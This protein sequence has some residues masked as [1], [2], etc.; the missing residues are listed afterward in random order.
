M[1]IA[2]DMRRSAAAMSGRRSSSCAGKATG[3]DG[4]SGDCILS[5]V[6]GR[7]KAAGGFPMRPDQRIRFAYGARSLC[8]SAGVASQPGHG[9]NSRSFH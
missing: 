2:A 1:P 3:T 6:G 8:L 9:R 4:N 7:L 5:G